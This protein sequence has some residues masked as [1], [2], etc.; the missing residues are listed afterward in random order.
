M[1]EAQHTHTIDA[2][3]TIET[4]RKNLKGR[5]EAYEIFYSFDSGL[6]VEAKEGQIDA[7]KARSN[8]GVGLRTLLKKRQG[9]GF[10]SVLTEE[11][12]KELVDKTLSAS[13]ESSEDDYLKFPKESAGS[14]TPEKLLGIFDESFGQASEEERLKIAL[15]IEESALS[16]DARIAR[17]RKASYQESIHFDRVVNSNGVD[18][19]HSATFYSGSVTAVAEEKGESQMGWE[20]GLGHGKNAVDP[21]AIGT[22]AAK[23]AVNL[24][25]ARKMGTI[26]C[27]AVL[28]N[29]VVCELLEALAGSLLGDN[30]HKGKSML[31]G[32]V[33]EKIAS[34][35]LNVYDD[36]LLP[37]G[38][39]SSPFDGEGV[40]RSKTP[41]ILNGVCQG[42]LYDSYWGERAGVK[43]TGN[44][45]RSNYKGFPGVGISNLYIGKGSRSLDD[46]FKELGKGLFVT[47]VLGVHTINTVSGD[48][49]L[50]AAGLWIENGSPA[51]P[52][53]GMAVSGNLL[54]IFLKAGVVASDIRFIGSIG[55]PSLLITEIEASGS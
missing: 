27:P 23:N 44:A 36:G 50:G 52:V 2:A 9:F 39:A 45:T 13:V 15:Q 40:M 55:A 33:G 32:K 22:G 24:M 35:V 42:Y 20:M 18:V 4:L 26:K 21:S 47:E 53:R 12:L 11:A 41:L 16:Y 19:S 29:T 49:S 6:G 7:L 10:S 17:V 1:S 51:Y 30:V 28:E 8:A 37:G 46:L 14:G 25:G 43:S 31:I 54:Q 34:E 3:K 5:A 48:F 38:W